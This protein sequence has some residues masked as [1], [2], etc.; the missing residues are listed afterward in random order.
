MNNLEAAKVEYL[1]KQAKDLISYFKSN[2]HRWTQM[3]SLEIDKIITLRA[4]MVSM[5]QI[6]WNDNL[7]YNGLK[8][9]DNFSA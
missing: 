5:S 3:L 6:L 1:I 2:G 4:S 8:N 9:Q 7:D